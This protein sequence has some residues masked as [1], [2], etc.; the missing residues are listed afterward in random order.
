MQAH[1]SSES[2]Q[3]GTGVA[4][5]KSRHQPFF[6]PVMVQPKLAVGAVDDPFERE[7]D[8]TADRVLRMPVDSRAFFKPRGLGLQSK[9]AIKTK[10]KSCDEEGKLRK[11]NKTDSEG[12][13]EAPEIIHD[14]VSSPGIPLDH[15][16]RNFFEPRFGYDFSN[17][18]VHTGNKA[19]FSSESINAHAYTVGN[20]VVFNEN[21]FAPQTD[22][23]KKL[24]AHELTHVV[25]QGNAK[26]RPLVQR[27]EVEKTMSDKWPDNII[28]HI[29][30]ALRNHKLFTG[31]TTGKLDQQ[32]VDGL[33]KV[34][35]KD[36]WKNYDHKAVL[37]ILTSKDAGWLIKNKP[38]EA[39]LNKAKEIKMPDCDLAKGEFLLKI[40]EDLAKSKCI[41]LSD[42]VMNK[43][44]DH[45]LADFNAQ[46]LPETNMWNISRDRI[47][48]F[49]AVYKDG[50]HVDFS[51]DALPK[52]KTRSGQ[53]QTKF[54]FDYE[55]KK[56]GK[57]YPIRAGRLYLVD[58]SVPNLSYLNGE[59]H[60]SVD[61]VIDELHKH[62]TLMDLT[63]IFGKY[64]TMLGGQASLN[65]M[66]IAHFSTPYKVRSGQRLTDLDIPEGYTS[67]LRARSLPQAF[68]EVLSRMGSLKRNVVMRAKL[69]EQLIPQLKKFD[70]NWGA[71]RVR[72]TDG[73]IMY[74]GLKGFAL[75]IDSN[76]RIFRGSINTQGHFIRVNRT[77]VVKGT[78]ITNEFTAEYTP[79][80]SSLKEVESN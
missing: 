28:R 29:Q 38:D 18:K 22:S 19:A 72:T 32:T 9:I 53:V 76:G 27:D 10:C 14:V 54:L 44:I 60:R 49:R 80:Y 69:F 52:S 17:V 15:K 16:T 79:V 5:N 34:F 2:K 74:L 59:L 35:Y 66:W 50:T 46:M 68:N 73:S 23:G 41:L 78:A 12:Q 20:H 62:A 13:T 30:R 37:G 47:T 77:T 43:Y 33:N 31:D 71:D 25:Q 3:Q 36:S 51:L 7:A 58:F 4:A 42:P 67:P 64:I 57:I 40:E 11:K 39:T 70:A 21:R 26:V 61:Y 8:E 1:L 75:V 45:N 56:D 55:L 24:L 63:V 48:S 6:G 65:N